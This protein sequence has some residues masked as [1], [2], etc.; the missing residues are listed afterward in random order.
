MFVGLS[1]PTIFTVHNQKN[2]DRLSPA[3]L[4]NLSLFII[5]ASVYP[6]II[7]AP[8]SPS[9]PF[10]S[11][12][13]NAS[14]IVSLPKNNLGIPVGVNQILFGL[15][16][17]NLLLSVFIHGLFVFAENILFCPLPNFAKFQKKLTNAMVMI[18]GAK[19][20]SQFLLLG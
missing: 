7:S 12:I 15:S 4:I 5:C 9:I 2:P 3:L 20:E 8:S 6:M 14:V 11:L 10:H 1:I 19:I 16:M 18:T 13:G 17:I